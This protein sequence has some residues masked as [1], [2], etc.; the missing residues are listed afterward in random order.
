MCITMTSK[1]IKKSFK[2]W[3]SYIFYLY[4]WPSMSTSFTSEDSINYG[5]LELINNPLY[6]LLKLLKIQYCAI[7][8]TINTEIST[9]QIFNK[10]IMSILLNFFQKI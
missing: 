1:T 3:T 10:E 2:L 4:S 6:C 8:N 9:D 7:C 5:N